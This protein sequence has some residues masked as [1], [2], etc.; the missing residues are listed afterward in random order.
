[1]PI[2]PVCLMTVE[3]A[4]AAA[5]AEHQNQTFYFCAE[6]CRDRFVLKPEEFLNGKDRSDNSVEDSAP[7]EKAVVAAHE[8]PVSVTIPVRGMSCSSCVAKIENRL[9]RLPGVSQVSVNFATEKAAVSYYPSIH[10][11]N[12]LAKAI[13]DIGYEALDPIE[14]QNLGDYESEAREKEVRRLRFKTIVGLVLSVPIFLGSFPEWFPWMPAALQSPWTLLILTTPVQFWIGWQFHRGF[15]NALKHGSSDMNTLVSVGTNAAYFYSL[16]LTLFPNELAPAGVMTMYYY[17]TSAILMALILMGRWLEARARGK[18]TEAIKKLMGLQAKTARVIRNGVESDIPV[19]EVRIGD[20]VLVRPGEQIPVDGVVEEG[21]SAVDESMLTGESVPVEK[22][23]GDEVIGATLNKTGSFKF[24]ASKVGK[25]TALARIVLLV[26]NAQGSKAPIQR[27]ADKISGIFVPIVVAIALATFAFWYWWGP[28]PAVIHA[29]TGFVAVLVIACPCALGLATPTAIIVGTGKGA[30]NGILIKGGESLERAHEISTVVF[31]KTGTLT[32]GQPS[33]T[34]VVALSGSF[35]SNEVLRLAASAERRSEHPFGQAIVM[36]AQEEKLALEDPAEF[37]A[38]P[39][40]GVRAVVAGKTILLGNVK[41][42]ET[43]GVALNGKAKQAE[44]F[45]AEG[46]TPM[47][48]AVDEELAGMIV[49]A[50]T[51]KGDAGDAVALLG[52]LGM[53]VV[54]ITG[55]NRRTAETIA[56]QVG[57]KHVLAEVLPE[58]KASEVKKLQGRGKIVA[59]VGDGINDAPALAQAD[60]GIA[61]GTGTDVAM[62]AA[63]ITLI[64]SELKA[65]VAAIQLSKQTMRTIRQNLF[66]AFFYNV[67]L[68]PVAAGILYFIFGHGGVPRLLQPVLGHDGLLSPVL[69]GA[70]MALSSVTVVSNSLRLRRFRVSF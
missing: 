21:A 42:M 31:D 67:A 30:E 59:M 44:T 45:S 53:E 6:V 47:F 61:L 35:S 22:K 41:L 8:K 49:V 56:R 24:R 16:G 20:I 1:M 55:D 29:L 23:T 38:V 15:W 43:H 64:R 34:D 32:Q 63:D 11:V 17:D 52:R 26:Q 7:A 48:V 12:D 10:S 65:V 54:M 39:G 50:D 69:A 4:T 66:W 18:T 14:E 46:K 13:R 19:E 60:V 68:I 51:L 40:H 33:V 25:D 57:I 58:D 28:E 2:D 3:E 37:Q 70:A 27:L 5:T 36:R 62:E 9:N